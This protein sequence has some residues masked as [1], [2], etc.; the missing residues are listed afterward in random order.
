MFQS[1]VWYGHELEHAI[2]LKPLAPLRDYFE[3]QNL[4]QNLVFEIN[5]MPY[6]TSEFGNITQ[7]RILQWQSRDT[8]I[9]FWKH[10]T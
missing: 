6:R 1:W 8:K 3:H 4:I 9:V 7:T 5:A 2:D 10:K